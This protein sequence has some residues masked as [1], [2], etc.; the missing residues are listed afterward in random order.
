MRTGSA[1][2]RTKMRLV[3]TEEMRKLLV[4]ANLPDGD[5]GAATVSWRNL[6]AAYELS[7]YA[8]RH[9]SLRSVCRGSEVAFERADYAPTG[10]NGNGG[11]SSSARRTNPFEKSSELTTLLDELQ[12]R[13]DQK[14]YDHMVRDVTARERRAE[15]ARDTSL[16]AYKEQMRFGAHVISMMAVFF[17][18][19]YFASHRVFPDS[20]AARL[21]CGVVGMFAAMVVETLLFAIKDAREEADRGGGGGGGGGRRRKSTGGDVGQEANTG[22]L[23]RQDAKAKKAD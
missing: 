12:R 3:V 22:R 4:A 1:R 14:R 20:A 16:S 9:V 13:L 15:A 19:G 5:P 23:A 8:S 17:L 10:G 18:M 11:P 6:A 21:L 2:N 7:D